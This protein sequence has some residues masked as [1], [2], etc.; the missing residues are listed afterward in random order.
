MSFLKRI[1]RKKSRPEQ[2][3]YIDN[4]PDTT[5]HTEE[6]SRHIGKHIG[7]PDRIFRKLMQHDTELDIYILQATGSRPYHVLVTSGM[8]SRPMP[9]PPDSMHLRYAELC[10]LLP[11]DWPLEHT[12]WNNENIYWPVRWLK[13]AGR[14]PHKNRTWI[15]SGH[16][17][18]DDRDPAP[19]AANTRMNSVLISS[20]R[21]LPGDFSVLDTASGHPIHFYVLLPLY[22][23]ETR[24][25][26][27]HGTDALLKLFTNAGAGD[28]IDPRRAPLIPSR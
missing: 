17:L 6:I 27:R 19:F 20:P 26:R 14:Y 22:P 1:F 18:P 12:D 25:A 7:R 28:I 10:I 21:D 23:S 3:L 15:A 5:S 2:V 4:A 8:S 11:P 9:V 24:Y 13:K 16:V